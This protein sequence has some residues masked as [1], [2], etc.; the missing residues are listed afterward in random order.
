MA[1]AAPLHA[2]T[3]GGEVFG[4][5]DTHAMS[6]W[7]D[8]TDLT[9][10]NGGD[11]EDP[12][13]SFGGGLG[14]RMWP[15]ANWMIAAT[16]EPIFLTRE[17]KVSGEELKLDANSFQG[18]VGY[19]F[20]TTGPGKFGLG[21]GVGFYSLNGEITGAGGGDLSG[22]T[23]G[24]HFMG[25]GEWTVSPGFAITGTAGY[26]IAKISDTQFNDQSADPE[27]ETDY[28]GLMLRAGLAFYMPSSSGQ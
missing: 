15:N 2:M 27:F 18:T 1:L 7:K 21:A 22:S 14:L 6:D 20:P 19:F 26:R 13:S 17:E 28:S 5:F 9:N 24:F 11:I 23:V 16:W 3:L 25:M 10:A 12:S 4:A 8:V